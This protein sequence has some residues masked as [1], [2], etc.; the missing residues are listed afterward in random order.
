MA[1]Y[2]PPAFPGCC[3]PSL[4][5]LMTKIPE[6]L[7]GSAEDYSLTDLL[8]RV[9]LI[10]PDIGWLVGPPPYRRGYLHGLESTSETLSSETFPKRQTGGPR[11]W[12]LTA[13]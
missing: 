3:P 4:P 5:V 8:I 6:E 7:R 10:R 11:N 13:L 1:L 2:A 9:T 12:P